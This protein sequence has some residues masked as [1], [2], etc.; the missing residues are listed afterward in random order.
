[1]YYASKHSAARKRSP[2]PLRNRL[3]GLAMATSAALITGVS[4]SPSAQAVQPVWFRV[5]ACESGGNWAVNTGNGYYG[6]L[7]FSAST[8]R[9]YGGTEYAASANRASV[10]V[11]IAIARRVLYSQGPG[12]WPVCG[13]RAGLTRANGGALNFTVSRSSARAPI[14]RRAGLAVDG[15]LGPK[16]TRAIQRWVGV[17]RTGFLGSRTVKGLQRKVK[18]RADGQIGPGTIRALQIRIGARRDGAG[19]LNRATVVALQRYLNRL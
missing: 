19:H 12:A 5:A 17:S 10:L 13:A 16:T 11:Q 2:R 7:Q 4:A 1:V 3:I 18:V 15:Q 6:G 14:F 8:W 9:M